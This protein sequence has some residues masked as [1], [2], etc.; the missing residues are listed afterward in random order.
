MVPSGAILRIIT[1]ATKDVSHDFLPH[2]TPLTP[3]REYVKKCRVNLVK[4]YGSEPGLQVGGALRWSLT[5][6]LGK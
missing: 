4:G 5:N 6:C 1:E 2:G 3:L